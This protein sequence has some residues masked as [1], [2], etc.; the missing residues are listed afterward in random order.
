MLDKGFA[1][2]IR[3]RALSMSTQFSTAC[4]AEEIPSPVAAMED[5]LND[6]DDL[7]VQN[8][9]AFVQFEAQLPSRFIDIFDL[10]SRRQL[11]GQSEQD[12]IEEQLRTVNTEVRPEYADLQHTKV[13]NH[14]F[15]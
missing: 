4:S 1:Q 3:C 14:G 11:L 2:L 6:G 12:C 13:T 5:D 7:A 15:T 10:D 8:N 9:L